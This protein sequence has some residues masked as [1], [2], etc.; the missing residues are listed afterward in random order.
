M[1]MDHQFRCLLVVVYLCLIKWWYFLFGRGGGSRGRASGP[2]AR[3]SGE[4]STDEEDRG[5]SVLVCS[6][7]KVRR[8][9]QLSVSGYDSS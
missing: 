7:L 5:S 4:S 8:C 3:R 2:H 1:R 9:E 6:V